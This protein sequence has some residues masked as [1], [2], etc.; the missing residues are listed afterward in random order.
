[1]VSNENRGGT[2]EKRRETSTL[3]KCA[4]ATLV[5]HTSTCGARALGLCA[6]KSP[7]LREPMR[8][9]TADSSLTSFVFRICG[10]RGGAG[11]REKDIGE[12]GKEEGRGEA[13]IPT[14]SVRQDPG[15]VSA[16]ESSLSF[17]SCPVAA[18]SRGA[19][20]N[21]QIFRLH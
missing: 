1:M 12:E 10:M 13:D 15:G 14:R 5:A 9:S 2:D 19:S 6:C 20:A 16:A 21:Y 3:E 17:R 11:R 8:T 4:C 18:D 7:C